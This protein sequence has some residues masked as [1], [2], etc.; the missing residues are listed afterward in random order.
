MSLKLAAR[1]V[2]LTP[3]KIADIT[4]ADTDPHTLDLSTIVPPETLAL[5]IMAERISGSGSLSGLPNNIGS[6]YVRIGNTNTSS[7]LIISIK[8]QTLPYKLTAA[9]DDWDL[10]LLGYFVQKRTR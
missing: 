7:P 1:F 4:H 5:Y 9:N 10:Y 6:K 3:T 8:D 2:T